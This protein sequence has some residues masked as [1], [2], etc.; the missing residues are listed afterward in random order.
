VLQR[1]LGQAQAR[2]AAT[3]SAADIAAQQART[4]AAEAALERIRDRLA[5]IAQETAEAE[6]RLE[7]VM[8]L[9]QDRVLGTRTQN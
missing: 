1:V 9:C 2:R 4:S 5:S 6:V 8:I 3:R 7:A